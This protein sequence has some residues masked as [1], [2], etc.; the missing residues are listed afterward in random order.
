LREGASGPTGYVNAIFEDREKNLWIGGKR[1]IERL[2]ASSFTSYSASKDPAAESSGAVYVD[3]SGRRWFAPSAGGLRWEK[4]DQQGYVKNDGLDHDV[5]Y[6]LS[7]GKN[8]LWI[9]RQRGGL[10]H[11]TY[12]NNRITTRTF[13]Q[14]NGLAENSIAA[15]HQ[16]RDGTV[17]A[18]GSTSG[19]TRIKNGTLTTYT[20]ANGLAS[21]T[22]TSILE[23]ADG[24]LWFA[25][26]N[27]L[28]SLSQGSWKSYG[29]QDGL[30]PGRINWLFEDTTGVLW[31]GS[32]N[33][34]AIRR[35]GK[36]QIPTRVPAA[37]REPILGIAADSNGFLWIST[38]H[39]ILRVYRDRLLNGDV[40]EAD[41][42]EFGLADGLR[43]VE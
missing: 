5:V 10:T 12:D 26:A 36:I 35:S 9:G 32:D 16:D 31:I 8:E 37:L 29:G 19:V 11:L 23:G 1:G 33:A 13:T 40:S 2:R 14:A 41:V 3:A 30:T 39:H 25:T 6:S 42:R 22:I 7:G 27:G 43:S 21:N 17:W 4:A 18:G 38:S 24:T 28:S 15:V 20:V 34:I